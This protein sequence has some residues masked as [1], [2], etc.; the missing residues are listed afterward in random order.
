VTLAHDGAA[1]VGLVGEAEQVGAFGVVELQGAGD[2][3]ED[4]RGGPS[5]CAAFELGVVLHTHF[6]QRGDLAAPEPGDATPPGGGEAGLL[7]ADLRAAG[8]E[9]VAHFGS[10]VHGF[11]GTTLSEDVGCT[12]STPISSDFLASRGAGALD[13]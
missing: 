10:V 6:G 7:G 3:V 4:A 2:G 5:E 1:A 8:G 9:K 11:D 13:A 12:G